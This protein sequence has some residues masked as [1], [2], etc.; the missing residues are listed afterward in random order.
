M[1]DYQ[2]DIEQDQLI[3]LKEVPKLLRKWCPTK[4]APSYGSIYRWKQKGVAGVRLATI[5]ISG[6]V[7]TSREALKHFISE[8]SRRKSSGRTAPEPRPSKGREKAIR[9]LGI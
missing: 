8:S 7:L 9:E 4:R 1:S 6:E 2:I 5:F 3:P